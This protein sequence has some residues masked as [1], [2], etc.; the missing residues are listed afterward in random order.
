MAWLDY[1]PNYLI[2]ADLAPKLYPDSENIKSALIQ[3]WFGAESD[4]N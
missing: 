3:R 2:G 1:I 4:S